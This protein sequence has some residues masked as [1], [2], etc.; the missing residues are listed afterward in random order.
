M[1]GSLTVLSE[2]LQTLVD[3]LHIVSIDVETEQDQPSRGHST[4]AVQET[5]GLKDEVVA[6]LTIHL[7]TQVILRERGRI[8]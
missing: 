8:R 4:Y 1:T 5:Q 2:S 7:L 3:Q 6:V